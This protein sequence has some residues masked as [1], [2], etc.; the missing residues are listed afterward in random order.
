VPV[1]IITGWNIELDESEMK[2]KWVDLIIHKPFEINQVLRLVKEGMIL[3][4]RLKQEKMKKI[5]K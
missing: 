5:P 4:G 2:D 3:R 1:A